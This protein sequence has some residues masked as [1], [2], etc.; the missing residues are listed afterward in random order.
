M[1]T[2]SCDTGT[3]MNAPLL[4][5]DGYIQAPL[6]FAAVSIENMATVTQS[7][8]GTCCK[9]A[10]FVQCLNLEESE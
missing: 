5:P 1:V 2:H 3:H 6:Q 8:K 7:Q 4:S 9:Q 10:A